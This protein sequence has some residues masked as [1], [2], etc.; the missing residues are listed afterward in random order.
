MR[1]IWRRTCYILILIINPNIRP[2]KSCDALH[3]PSYTTAIVRHDNISM[4]VYYCYKVTRIGDICK[5]YSNDIVESRVLKGIFFR[6]Y[7][8]SSGH[9]LFQSHVHITCA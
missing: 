3:T 2:W 7:R 4:Y 8:H 1:D 9:F 6:V 5:T